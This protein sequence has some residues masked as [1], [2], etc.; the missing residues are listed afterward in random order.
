MWNI[1]FSL[2]LKKKPLLSQTNKQLPTPTKQRLFGKQLKLEQTVGKWIFTGHYL[3]F[4][5]SSR[6]WNRSPFCQT[7][8]LFSF[9][10]IPGTAVG[11][12]EL[13]VQ[14][15]IHQRLCKLTTAPSGCCSL[16][17]LLFCFFASHS[18][19]G[20]QSNILKVSLSFQSSSSGDY[21]A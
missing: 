13:S 6:P 2:T 16:S 10:T 12:V 21:S 19:C 14:V 18:K 8:S 20:W 5:C 15:L 1:Q 11:D 17:F 4:A 3:I 9:H 7:H